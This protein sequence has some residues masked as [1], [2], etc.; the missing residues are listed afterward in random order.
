MVY[1]VGDAIAEEEDDGAR[2]DA[3]DD[4]VMGVRG[5][6]EA[7]KGVVVVARAAVTPTPPAGLEAG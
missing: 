4:E 3:D 5:E 2:D 7:V 1:S 6:A